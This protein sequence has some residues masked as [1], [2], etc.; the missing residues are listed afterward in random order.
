MIVFAGVTAPSH[1]LRTLQENIRRAH[2]WQN[3][4]C[5]AVGTQLLPIYVM[6]NSGETQLP[7]REMLASFRCIVSVFYLCVLLS[8]WYYFWRQQTSSSFFF[9]FVSPF[10]PINSNLFFLFYNGF[11]FFIFS[12][13]D[14]RLRSRFNIC[15][16][17]AHSPLGLSSS[18]FIGFLQS[19]PALVLSSF[20]YSDYCPQRSDARPPKLVPFLFPHPRKNSTLGTR[21]LLLNLA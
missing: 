12:A 6:W 8:F 7:R 5:G 4:Q 13:L 1:L 17:S 18:H 9:C 21:P 10:A 2:G 11:F 20:S 19:S 3:V 14:L 15:P 16:R